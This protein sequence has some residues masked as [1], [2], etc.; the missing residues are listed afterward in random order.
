[1]IHLIIW[2]FKLKTC[3]MIHKMKDLKSLYL[4]F[5]LLFIVFFNLEKIDLEV[6][7]IC[8]FDMN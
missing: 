4:L 7:Y 8:F 6:G 2:F 5:M 1:M 3:K